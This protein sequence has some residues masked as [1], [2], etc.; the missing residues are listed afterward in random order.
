ML[1]A[2]PNLISLKLHLGGAQNGSE[3]ISDIARAASRHKS[4]KRFYLDF[5][6]NLSEDAA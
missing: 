5:E 4:L 1:R 6:T 3:V 2:N